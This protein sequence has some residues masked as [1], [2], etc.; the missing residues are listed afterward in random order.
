[1]QLMIG[2]HDLKRCSAPNCRVVRVV[3]VMNHENYSHRRTLRDVALLR[4]CFSP[5]TAAA[6]PPPPTPQP[7]PSTPPP[8]PSP[9]LVMESLGS[10]EGGINLGSMEGA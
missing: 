3:Q 10:R 6:A 1:M 8:S 2:G 5:S 7:H 9:P 4:Y